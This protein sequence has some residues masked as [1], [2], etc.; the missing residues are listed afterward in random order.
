MGKQKGRHEHFTPWQQ[1]KTCAIDPG[2]VASMLPSG[3]VPFPSHPP[4]KFNMEPT[5]NDDFI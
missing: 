2:F 4:K 5:K 1:E 3:I